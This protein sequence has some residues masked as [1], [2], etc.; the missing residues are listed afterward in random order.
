MDFKSFMVIFLMA[1][2]VNVS[3]ENLYSCATGC[4]NLSQE[5]LNIARN[6]SPGTRYSVIDFNNNKAK[7]F[8]SELF[9]NTNYGEPLERAVEVT[10]SSNAVNTLNEI[11]A[12]KREAENSRY[13]VPT[14]IASSA[15]DLIAM[16]QTKVLVSRHIKENSNLWSTINDFLSL[17]EQKLAGGTLPSFIIVVTFDDNSTAAYSIANISYTEGFVFEYVPESATSN[18]GTKIPT[19]DSDFIGVYKFENMLEANN[20]AGL[21]GLY[22][23]LFDSNN[24]CTEDPIVTCTKTSAGKY[25]CVGRSTFQ[26]P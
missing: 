13:Q 24:I 3:A 17:A 18:S 12:A 10:T 1:F 20:F 19:K 5:A 15:Y 23:I 16:P 26:C 6:S 4:N 7:T 8:V 25:E 2:S 14:S 9:Y 22:G 11:N 21:A